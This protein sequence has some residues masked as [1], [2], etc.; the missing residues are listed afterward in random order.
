MARCQHCD[1]LIHLEHLNVYFD[2]RDLNKTLELP[3]LKGWTP[4]Y[5][6]APCDLG[7]ENPYEFGKLNLGDIIIHFI[8][9]RDAEDWNNPITP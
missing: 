7:I 6:Y 4:K 2:E 3:F 1:K 9:Q 8:A 5:M